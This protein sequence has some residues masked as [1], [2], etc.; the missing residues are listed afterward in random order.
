MRPIQETNQTAGNSIR[1]TSFRMKVLLDFFSDERLK[2]TSKANRLYEACLKMIENGYWMPGDKIPPETSLTRNLPI[3]L[4]TTQAALRRLTQEGLIHRKRRAG[5]FVSESKNS[6]RELSYFCFLAE[7]GIS[8]LPIKGISLNVFETEKRGAWSD[9]VGISDSY[10]CIE[11]IIEVASKFRLFT[12]IFL[13]DPKFRTLLTYPESELLELNIRNVLHDQF[14]APPLGS[15]RRVSSTKV[16]ANL[17]E[18]IGCSKE[19]PAM[20]YEILQYSFR[21]EPLF[22]METIIPENDCVL[23][24]AKSVV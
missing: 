22:F 19:S 12:R 7:G 17:A 14:G 6:E 11:R 16:T 24:I 15:E 18:R 4:A 20:K 21:S 5:S 8:Y 23:Q 10:I 2:E 1:H 3:G 13:C 9:F